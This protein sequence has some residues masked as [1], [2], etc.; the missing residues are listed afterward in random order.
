MAIEQLDFHQRVISVPEFQKGMR[1]S[2]TLAEIEAHFKRIEAARDVKRVLTN[3]RMNSAPEE[4]IEM[5]EESAVRA[6]Q[7]ARVPYVFRSRVF[8]LVLEVDQSKKADRKVREPEERFAV[9][10]APIAFHGLQ[11]LVGN[12]RV[13]VQAKR[14][15]RGKAIESTPMELRLNQAGMVFDPDNRPYDIQ[16]LDPL[17]Q[18]I[19]YLAPTDY[20]TKVRPSATS[21][22]AQKRKDYA[23][24]MYGFH[25]F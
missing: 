4:T 11:K 18:V 25:E 5:L 21:R 22:G 19:G 7:E 3:A 23:K 14:L 15:I 1:R 8:R 2:P 17:T 16:E 9:E 20:A 24:A 10:F 12:S 13:I 6:N